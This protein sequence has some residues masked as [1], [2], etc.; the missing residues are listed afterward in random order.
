MNLYFLVLL[1]WVPTGFC[2][3]NA[4][5]IDYSY[6]GKTPNCLL[7]RL[8]TIVFGRTSVLRMMFFLFFLPTRYLRDAWE[9]RR[10][11][12]QD[13]QSW[14]LFY[15]AGPKF[16]KAHRK[17][18]SG[19][20]N[21]QNLARFRTTSKFGGEYLRSGWR[22]SKSDSHSVYRNSS[23]VRRNKYGEVWSSDLGDLDFESYPPKVHFSEDHISTPRGTA[24]PNFYTR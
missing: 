16:W 13:G 8:K 24:P 12:L 9:D 18:S 19:A 5:R 20:K 23:C 1:C 2:F 22:Y 3:Y 14:A 15:N 4:R 21:M 7:V 6:I 10:E 11:I 17:K